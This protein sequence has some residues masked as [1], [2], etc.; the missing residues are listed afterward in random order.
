VNDERDSTPTQRARRERARAADT[1]WKPPAE[2]VAAL[3]RGRR[4]QEKRRGPS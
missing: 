4:V 2:V 3:R 1:F